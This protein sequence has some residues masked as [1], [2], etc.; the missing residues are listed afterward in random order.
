MEAFYGVAQPQT[1]PVFI[2]GTGRCGSTLLSQIIRAHPRLLSI[3][4]FFS[5]LSS[6]ALR[7]RLIS[8]EAIARRLDTLPM[9]GRAL[10][11]NGLFFEEFQYRFTE[12]SRY[13]PGNL[14]PILG[15]TLPHLSNAPE[16][17]WD[18]LRPAISRRQRAPLADQYRFVFGWLMEKFERDL[19]VERSGASLG[20]VAKLA[21]MF[22]EARFVHIYRDGR[23]T[24]LSMARHPYFI[25]R[26]QVAE[27]MRK[28]G[29]DPF[30][31]F[32]TPGTSPWIPPFEDIRF[33]FFS[34]RQ[35]EKIDLPLDAFGRFWSDMVIRGCRALEDLEPE[36]L[37]SIRYEQLTSS[38]QTEL[39][40]L[41]NFIGEEFRNQEWLEASARLP[42]HRPPNWPQLEASKRASLSNACAPGQ[43]LLGYPKDAHDRD[44]GAFE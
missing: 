37:H 28:V 5:G 9:A 22:P 27:G 20:Y 33:R 14:P 23:D 4:E 24:A 3:S 36:R 13:Q 35:F 10:L 40:R 32:N 8:G 18:E 44:S 6:R 43:D 26:T 7:G 17:L 12:N 19:W 11:T 31:R 39:D 38:P 41:I 15:S 2:V 16:A 21:E 34:R 1:Q 30:S 25:I 29:L 42:K